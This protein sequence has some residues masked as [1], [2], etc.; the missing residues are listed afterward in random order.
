M[1]AGGSDAFTLVG[2]VSAAGHR[3]IYYL[4]LGVHGPRKRESQRKFRPQ[5]GDAGAVR[6]CSES[7]G[8]TITIVPSAKMISEPEYPNQLLG[9]AGDAYREGGPS[10]TTFQ[11]SSA[12]KLEMI[13]ISN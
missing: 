3:K 9:L 6:A 1:S 4:Q 7:L 12:D 11:S 13:S 5:M 8:G 10:S 2:E